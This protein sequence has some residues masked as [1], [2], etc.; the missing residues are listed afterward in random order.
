MRFGRVF[1]DRVGCLPAAVRVDD[2]RD[3][4][5]LPRIEIAYAESAFCRTERFIVQ[6]YFAVAIDFFFDVH[7]FSFYFFPFPYRENAE[8]GIHSHCNNRFKKQIYAELRSA[9]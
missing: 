7:S 5:A 8:L 1:V 6:T 3:D 9:F 2:V 4:E